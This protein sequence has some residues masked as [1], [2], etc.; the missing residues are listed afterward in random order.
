[1]SVTII[2]SL[3]YT[4]R[5]RAGAAECAIA[6]Q[7][8]SRRALLLAQRGSELTAP[9]PGELPGGQTGEPASSPSAP[10]SRKT[11]AGTPATA[12]A[13]DVACD[14]RAGRDHGV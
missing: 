11:C 7:E 12:F 6:C 9:S 14:D 2:A 3:Y 8:R 1:M 13:A 4:G 10:I 5:I